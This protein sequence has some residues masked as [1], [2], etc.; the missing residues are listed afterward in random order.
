MNE[1]LKRQPKSFLKL[2][3]FGFL[4][5]SLPFFLALAYSAMSVNRL[6]NLSREAVHQAESIA[7]GSRILVEQVAIMERSV[8]LSLI[9]SDA[10]MLEGYYQAHGEFAN[11]AAGLAQLPLKEDQ[12]ALLDKLRFQ[13]SGIYGKIAQH[14]KMVDFAPLLESAQTF[15]RRGDEPIEHEV[16]VM[17]AMAGQ[18]SRIVMWQLAALVPLATLLAFGFSWLINRPIRQIDESIKIMGQG[19]LSRNITVDGPED[20]KR[21]ADRLNWMRLRLLDLEEEKTRFLQ[22]VSHELKTPLTSIRE[23]ADLLATGVTGELNPKQGQVA[24]ILL[25]NSVELQKRIEDL[26]SYSAIQA[27]KPMPAWTNT[28]LGKILD[29]VLQDQHLAIMNK[30][31]EIDLACPNL[32]LECDEQKIRVVIDNLLSNAVKFSPVGGLIKIRG[33]LE[34]DHMHLDII[35]SGPGIDPLDH[36]RIFD[37]FYQGR[38]TAQSPTRGTGLGLSI[39]SEYAEAHKGSI[40]LLDQEEGTCFRLTLPRGRTAS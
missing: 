22:H 24:R 31:I 4:L 21:L 37:A 14:E 25:D 39:A 8:R 30:S 3:L 11:T 7:H 23:G 13:E 19:E 34:G 9:L 17:Q 27:G 18:A 40:E 28:D 29:A 6:A 1:L 10:T 36:D 15:L 33:E 32:A 5:V 12:K 26:L 35:D 2:I 16:D 38:R 20:L